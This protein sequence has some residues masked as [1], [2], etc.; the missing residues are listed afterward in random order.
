MSSSLISLGEGVMCY[1]SL[2]ITAATILSAVT[3]LVKGKYKSSRWVMLWGLATSMLTSGVC[4][5]IPDGPILSNLIGS[6]PLA[7]GIS[8]ALLPHISMGMEGPDVAGAVI[9]HSKLLT[10]KWF[11]EPFSAMYECGGGRCRMGVGK[12]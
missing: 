7:M 5:L 3:L 6:V 1:K 8:A 11:L 2:T 4:K 10:I 9:E 12:V